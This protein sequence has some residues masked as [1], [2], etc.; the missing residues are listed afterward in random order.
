MPI[1]ISAIASSGRP[2]ISP[3]RRTGTPAALAASTTMRR[4]KRRIAGLSQS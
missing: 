3:H 2:P 4:R 1:P